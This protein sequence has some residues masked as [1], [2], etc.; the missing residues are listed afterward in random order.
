MTSDP[1]VFLYSFTVNL[2]DEHSGE[3]ADCSIVISVVSDFL[4]ETGRAGAKKLALACGEAV[5]AAFETKYAWSDGPI[6]EEAN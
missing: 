5:K 3:V 2:T 1:E 6:K 4:S